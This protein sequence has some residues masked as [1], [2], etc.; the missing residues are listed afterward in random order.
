MSLDDM[1]NAFNR[2]KNT[3]YNESQSIVQFSD[4]VELIQK[5]N[6]SE[7]DV[8]TM[9][10]IY[11]NVSILK[12]SISNLGNKILDLNG[13]RSDAEDGIQVNKDNLDIHTRDI[14]FC[15]DDFIDAVAALNKTYNFK[16]S[17]IELAMI[18]ELL[19]INRTSILDK[20]RKF[21]QGISMRPD[22]DAKITK[23]EY[24][25]FLEEIIDIVTKEAVKLSVLKI[26]KII[27]KNI[28][29]E[30]T[31]KNLRNS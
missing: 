8:Q 26:H 28:D 29:L 4:L 19:K 11:K 14:V 22:L 30:E 27:K 16:E 23:E 7:E 5:E 17:R 6:K 18:E 21:K 1:Q 20:S 25:K 3:I 13:T 15:L 10:N 24:I 9:K 31:K 2:I 12:E